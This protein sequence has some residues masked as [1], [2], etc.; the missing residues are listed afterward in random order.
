SEPAQVGDE[1]A[2]G[3][4]CRRRLVA[5]VAKPEPREQC[6]QD[7]WQSD[8]EECDAPTKVL[9]DDAAENRREHAGNRWRGGEN[10]EYE[11]ALA[12]AEVVRD[13]RMRDRNASSLADAD[14]EATER[15]LHEVLRC[16]AKR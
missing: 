13:E 9:G 11:P 15:E 16:T 2:L 14:A 6:E 4:L 7:A 5:S 12:H 8:A 3:A 1:I 10:R